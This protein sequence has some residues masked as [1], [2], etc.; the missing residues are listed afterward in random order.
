MTTLLLNFDL[1]EFVA[2]EFGVDVDKKVVY[3]IGKEG[4]INLINILKKFNG[5][6]CT[7]FTTYTFSEYCK[8][9]INQLIDMG[10]EIALHGYSHEQDYR[11]MEMKDIT[12]YVTLAKKEIESLFGVK[13]EGFRAQ[14]MRRIPYDIL[15]KMKIK[16]DSSLHPTYVPGY[17]NSFFEP[18]KIFV[19][20]NVT[21]IPVT[22][23]PIVKLPFSWIWFRNMGLTYSK[24]CTSLA[25]I[26]SKHINIYFHPWEFVDID[27]PI[28][29]E[30]MMS[31]IMKNTGD[32]MNRM[33]E[34]Y[35]RW[36][37]NSGFKTSTIK[38]YLNKK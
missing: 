23:T 14:Q 38:D 21:V 31:L 9:Q 5:L 26:D 25:R 1:E 24:I 28:Y 29:R 8:K 12:K 13:I 30:K 33:M 15:A 36:S 11:V 17:Y 7:F 37:I 16:Y 35:I 18:R 2:R 34:D 27:K 4:L 32:K 20:E 3:D 19:K 22:V 6:K 10:H